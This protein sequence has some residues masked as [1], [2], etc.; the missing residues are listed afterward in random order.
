MVLKAFYPVEAVIVAIVLGFVPYP[1]L[2]RVLVAR[3]CTCGRKPV[4]API[5]TQ[6]TL[7]PRCH[8]AAGL[9]KLL[10]LRVW[11]SIGRKG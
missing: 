1:L 4:S 11:E 10:F 2:H 5:C 6:H 7:K 8:I 9:K 3:R